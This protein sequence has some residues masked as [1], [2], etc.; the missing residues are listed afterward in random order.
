VADMRRYLHSDSDFDHELHQFAGVESLD[1]YA[2]NIVVH[3]HTSAPA[4]REY[5][6]LPK[7]LG[8]PSPFTPAL[9]DSQCPRV[10]C[11][12]G[13]SGSTVQPACLCVA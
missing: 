9:L 11:A 12:E 4:T 6:A 5:R 7:T 1:H 13:L 2:V 3:V 8:A 10:S